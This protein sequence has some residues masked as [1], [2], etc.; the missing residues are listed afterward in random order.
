MQFGVHATGGTP[1]N[2]TCALMDGDYSMAVADQSFLCRYNTR[3]GNTGTTYQVIVGT[4]TTD[5]AGQPLDPEFP[6][7]SVTLNV[8][9][10]EGTATLSISAVDVDEGAG[11]ATVSVTVDDEVTGGFSVDAMT[12]DDAATAT[13]DADYTTVSGETLSFTGATAGETLSFTVPILEDTIY[14]GGTSGVPETVA[15]ALG[16]LQDTTRSVDHSATATISITDNEYQVALT[17]EDVSVSEDAV[18][19]T[20]SVSL[21]TAVTAAFSVVAST[22]PGTA[23]AP[24]DYTAVPSQTLSFTGAPAGETQTFS[25]PIFNDSMRELTETLTVSLSNLDVPT[26]TAT[27]VGT[28]RPVSA[29]ITIMDD[30]LSAGGVNLNLL[31]PVTV[32]GKTWFYL[33]QNGNGIAD[34]GD[35]VSHIVLDSLLNGGSDTEATQDGAHDGRD[36]ARSVIVGDTAVILPTVDELTAL[37]SSLSDTAPTNWQNLSSMEEYWTANLGSMDLRFFFEYSFSDGMVAE[38]NPVNLN[39]VA[40]QV[41]E[42]P[43]FSAGIADQTYMIG[44]PVTLMLPEAAGGVGTL[45]YTLTRDDG[46]PAALPAGLSF[47]P[48]A[49][50]ISGTPS[51]VFGDTAGASMRYT[52]TDS[53]GAVRDIFFRLRVVVMTAL[54][55]ENIVVNEGAGTATVSVVLNNAVAGS[56]TVDVSS[57]N[58]SATAGANAIAIADEDY[59]A[60]SETLTFA[61]TENEMQTFS[62]DIT[63]DDAAEGPEMLT[64]SLGNLQAPTAMVIITDTATV[65]I[66]DDDIAVLTVAGAA[67]FESSSTQNRDIVATVTLLDAVPGGFTVVLATA[68]GTATAS[69]DYTAISPTLTF[70]GDAGESQ[71]VNIPVLADEDP[72][73]DETVMLSFRDLDGT[74]ADVNISATATGTIRVSDGGIVGFGDAVIVDQV[75]VADT[76]IAPLLL[77]E[78]IAADINDISVLNMLE[79]TLTPTSAIP[80]GLSFDAAT[81]TLRG[82]PTML[83]ATPAILTYTARNFILLGGNKRFSATSFESTMASLTFSVTVA[84]TG[85]ASV[86]H[87]SDDTA[88]TPITDLVSGGEIYSVVVFG[89][90][91]RNEN[92]TDATA[93]PAIASTLGDNT[94]VTF[95]IV[96]YNAALENGNCRATLA[97]DTSRYTCRYS[98]ADSVAATDPGAYTVSVSEARDDDSGADLAAYNTDAGVTIGVRPTVVEPVTYYSDSLATSQITE[99]VSGGVIYARIQFSE[100]VQHINGPF[101]Q[102][103]IRVSAVD[104]GAPI[105]VVRENRYIILAQDAELR[106]NSCRAQVA[107]NTSAYLCQITLGRIEQYLRV[108]VL[109]ETHDLAGHTLAMDFESTDFIVNDAPAPVVSSITHYADAAVTMPISDVD[110]V[111]G[112][113]IYSLIQFT[114]LS[115]NERDLEVFHQLGSATQVPFGIQ[116]AVKPPPDG[117]CDR[118]S[119][120]GFA[121]N[122]LIRCHYSVGAADDGLYQVI[123]GTDTMDLLGQALNTMDSVEDSGVRISALRFA[124]AEIAD[125]NYTVGQT[126]ALTL[127]AAAGGAAPFSYTLTRT[128]GPETLPTELAFDAGEAH[129]QRRPVERAVRRFRRRRHELH[130]DGRQRQQHVHPLHPAGQCSAG[131]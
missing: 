80:A 57:M 99:A 107:D 58:G 51:V 28:L 108:Q 14:E 16:N 43:I 129:H 118:F 128:D 114:G 37:G 101:G 100:N 75:Y 56:F 97:D 35:A 49:R 78:P 123:V 117:N 13:A 61:G 121:P 102:P 89:A 69:E 85:V 91:V 90:N 84:E 65:T 32:N 116:F 73:R 94:P 27:T 86:R 59:T 4:G 8:A 29:T 62:V 10:G 45:S 50:T 15:V 82:M 1:E 68:D 124:T 67:S 23:T 77:P 79:Y 19:A 34:T 31:F 55:M 83:T 120:L 22:A 115:I 38:A 25:V 130:G 104:S 7:S 126:V 18:T 122:P 131:L 110:V 53:T 98:V 93:R 39:H 109:Q 76:A 24:G 95:G 26:D 20:I 5:T 70:F 47:D 64:L 88:A 3:T 21:D 11:T 74:P 6:S 33:D 66:N 40:F 71:D 92:A 41:H 52:A 105:D 46:S 54:T 48:A 44:Q 103:A 60:V 72:E 125:Q 119:V 96:A 87:Y 113:D 17:M 63:D 30:D 42:L 106:N 9:T 2:G 36:D 12:V 127:P 111:S 81:H 112:G